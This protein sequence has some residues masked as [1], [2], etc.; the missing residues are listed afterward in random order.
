MVLGKEQ[1][2]WAFVGIFLLLAVLTVYMLKSYLS[3]LVVG[4]FIAYFLYPLSCKLKAKL[5]KQVLVEAVLS[6]GT[7]LILLVVSMALIVPVANQASS[8]YEE[9]DDY[10]TVS[11]DEHCPNS[12]V[13]KNSPRFKG[14]S[15]IKCQVLFKLSSFLDNPVFK[16]KF[17]GVVQKVSGPLASGVSDLFSFALSFL[18]ALVVVIFTVFYLLENGG[19][20]KDT[21]VRALPLKA[22][23]KTKIVKRFRDTIDAV[24]KGSIVT[25]LLQGALGALMFWILGIPLALFW[26]MVMVF[27]S[28]IPAVGP[29]IIWVPAA[30]VLFL[31]GSYV[32]G[33]LMV[34][35][36]FVVLG[37]IDNVLKPKMIGDKIQLS[38]FAIL[39]GVMGG[40][41]LFGIIGLF[42]G[43]VVIALLVTFK[44][45]YFEMQE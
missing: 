42:L 12:V 41:E 28:F 34:V 38:S 24:V 20:L 37:Y 17:Q 5:K 43:P 36:G 8:L 10:L 45:I 3:A 2:K 25:A 32:K 19:S 1:K 21:F 27:L 11:F 18:V 15:S 16:G 39:L 22:N 31:T 13:E 6:V 26:G 23:Y 29:T 9:Y 40:L 35:F 7:V 30:I 4:G 44:D 33:I 14:G